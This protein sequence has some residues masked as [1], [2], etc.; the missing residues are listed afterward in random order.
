MKPKGHTWSQYLRNGIGLKLSK[1]GER[2]GCDALTYNPV[3]LELFHSIALENA[4]KVVSVLRAAYPAV[5]SVV[6]VGCGSGAF[7]AEFTRCGV[8]AIGFERSPHGIQLAREQGVDCRHFDVSLP[9]SGDVGSSMGDLVYSFE[10]AE[11]VPEN[12]AENFIRFISMCGN[13]VAF[14]AAQ[15]GQG[16]IGHINEQYPS[17]W[18]KIFARHGFEFCD[19]ETQNVRNAFMDHSTSDWFYKNTCIYRRK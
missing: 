11:H 5:S 17:Y 18:E 9:I 7:A 10:V 15:P 1:L 3:I 12:L 19:V 6:D 16:G 2:F 14:A 4:P 8:K 13:L